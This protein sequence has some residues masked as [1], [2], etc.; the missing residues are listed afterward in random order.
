MDNIKNIR[1]EYYD[2][3]SKYKKELET[4][5]ESNVDDNSYTKLHNILL[6]NN[7]QS[8]MNKWD[9][10]DVYDNLEKLLL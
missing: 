4:L 10:K 7:Y 5:L 1:E 8:L 3:Y 2:N 6:D 9:K